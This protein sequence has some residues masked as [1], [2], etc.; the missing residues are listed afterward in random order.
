MSRVTT[1]IITVLCQAERDKYSKTTE[2][3][4]IQST[5]MAA[6]GWATEKGGNEQV[7]IEN[8]R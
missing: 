4:E 3:I 6:R 1:Q 5:M 8:F 2:F 7:L